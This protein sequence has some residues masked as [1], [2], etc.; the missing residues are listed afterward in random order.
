[1]C[2]GSRRCDLDGVSLQGILLCHLVHSMD[3]A[4]W[5]AGLE[6]SYALDAGS[7]ATVNRTGNRYSRA[8]VQH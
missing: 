1:M 4:A 6:G 8:T 3:G 2:A 5:R 7:A